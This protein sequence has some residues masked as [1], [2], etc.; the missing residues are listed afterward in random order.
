MRRR[1]GA[2]PGLLAAGAALAVAG[3]GAADA[4]LYVM[5]TAS[6]RL[7]ERAVEMQLLSPTG[8]ATEDDTR[9]VALSGAVEATAVERDR[10]P[11]TGRLSFAPPEGSTGW[12]VDGPCQGAAAF[13]AGGEL[14]L[15]LW[16]DARPWVEHAVAV[17]Y[18]PEARRELDAVDLGATGPVLESGS[19][20]LAFRSTPLIDAVPAPCAGGEAACRTPDGEP[21]EVV[22]DRVLWPVVRV[23][24]R[25]DRLRAGVDVAATRAALPPVFESERTLA[26]AFGLQDD[27][28]RPRQ[29]FYQEGTTAAGRRC[30]RPG[31]LGRATGR[32]WC[33]ARAR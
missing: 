20:W 19:G 29:P 16:K 9:L 18:D 33:E 11:V 22:R 13:P 25:G 32:W 3:A 7:D 15:V 17:L 10:G 5:G 31:R 26:D 2:V 6:C 27:A 12:P 24:V 23:A 8:E 1:A 14:V 28:P 30:L 21:L 4:P